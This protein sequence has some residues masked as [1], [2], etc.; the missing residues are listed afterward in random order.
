MMINSENT[1]DK[2]VPSEDNQVFNSSIHSRSGSSETP[3]ASIRDHAAQ[4]REF[5][6]NYDDIHGYLEA[7]KSDL[8]HWSVFNH[9]ITSSEPDPSDVIKD[10]KGVRG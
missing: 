1:D 8:V 6:P 9:N 4:V 2:K 5:A 10:L 3:E 7:S